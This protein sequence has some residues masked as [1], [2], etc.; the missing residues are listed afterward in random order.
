MNFRQ[1]LTLISVTVLV[2]TEVLG[3]SLA[4]G[5]AVGGLFQLGR[6]LTWGIVAVC[7]A[8]GAWATWRFFDM[9]R[10][11]EPQYP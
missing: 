8:A 2:G 3:A 10:R 6:E 7:A 5:W 11:V 1:L 4:F 9:A